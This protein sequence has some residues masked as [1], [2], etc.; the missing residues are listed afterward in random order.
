MQK[1][2]ILDTGGTFNKVYNP[3]KGKLEISKNSEALNEILRYQNNLDCSV[4]GIIYKDSLDLDDKD[5]E[6]ILEE[7]KK[8][9]YSKI[10]II[11]GTDTM[12]KTAKFIDERVKDKMVVITG[13]MVPFSI[14]EI[15]AALNFSTAVGF[16]LSSFQAGVYISMHGMVELHHKVFKN[17]KIG[18]FQR[19]G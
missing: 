10:I 19:V 12:D 16:L 2:F 4:K 9:I 1:I 6:L 14:R 7:I 8:S 13:A 3:L 18:I 11:H 5:R 15:E 17:R